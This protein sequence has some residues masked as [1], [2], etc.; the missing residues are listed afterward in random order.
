MTIRSSHSEAPVAYAPMMRFLHHIW[1]VRCLAPVGLVALPCLANSLM[2]LVSA[3][4]LLESSWLPHTLTTFAASFLKVTPCCR[5]DGARVDAMCAAFVFGPGRGACT[6]VGCTVFLTFC[7][8]VRGCVFAFTISRLA[9]ID[10][11]LPIGILSFVLA[12]DCFWAVQGI[13]SFRGFA[14]DLVES[15]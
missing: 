6:V 3:C 12:S 7:F 2:V 8:R 11:L 9:W 4:W 10:P 15:R 5:W 14:G 1:G 13:N